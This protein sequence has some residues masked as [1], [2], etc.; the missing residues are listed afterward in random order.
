[1]DFV[2]ADQNLME[3]GFLNTANGIDLEIGNK[4]AANDF[5]LTLPLTSSGYV[6]YGK[7][8]FVPGT[9]YGGIIEDLKTST[10]SGTAQW[11]G[12]TWRGFLNQIIIEPTSGAAYKTVSG[13]ANTVLKSMLS[14]K[15][16]NMFTVPVEN[17]G[18]TVNYQFDRYVSYLDGFS[19]MLA[20]Y[21]ARLE[22]LAEQGRAN[23]AFA[24]YL[25][26]VPVMDYSEEVEYSQDNK[27]NFVIRDYRRGINHLICLGKGELTA[28]QVL[29]LYVQKGGSVGTT[30]Y[31]TGLEERTAVYD[32]SSAEDAATL[33]EYGI[34][35]LQEIMNYKKL[36]MSVQDLNL[37]IGDIVAGRERNT[38]T[39]LKKPIARKVLK[40]DGSKTTIEYKVEGED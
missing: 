30:K 12:N 7:Y 23:E 2:I 27:I 40:I 18:I 4:D 17:S 21:G 15:L 37:A 9:E 22:I 29:H 16:N 24:V 20:Q 6:D 36:E 39:Y 19:S 3:E 1:M 25:K 13:E 5:E 34:K 31:Y 32:Y 26:A 28:R 10:S 33:K 38:G 14:G 8:I 11:Y 35:R